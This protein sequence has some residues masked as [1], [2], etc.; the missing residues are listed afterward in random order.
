M[1]LDM[2]MHGK[3]LQFPDYQNP[4]LSEKKHGK[5]V[6]SI[7]VELGYWRKHPDLHGYIVENFACNGE[8]NCQ[9]IYMTREMM[10]QLIDAVT[11][12]AL[13]HGTTGFF[14]GKS[15]QPGESDQFGTY[16][17][18]KKFDLE[19]LQQALDWLDA[20]DAE[21]KDKRRLTAPG[22]EWWP[23]IEYVASW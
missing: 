9:P 23:S 11:N 3:L 18:Q 14:F 22:P 4:D 5:V 10:L 16:E 12:D 1:G 21:L 20:R 6:E 17:D 7:T 8:D 2:H 19:T 13:A 15:Y